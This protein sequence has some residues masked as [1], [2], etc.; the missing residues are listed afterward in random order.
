MIGEEIHKQSFDET[1]KVVARHTGERVEKRQVEEL[2]VR[3]A[4]DFDAFYEER[5]ATP[6]EG[7]A[8]TADIIA[9]TFDGKGVP[10]HPEALRKRTREAAKKAAAKKAGA[11]PL[12]L[13]RPR[14][15]DERRD[16]KRMATVAAVYMTQAFFRTPE[17]V[18]RELNHLQVVEPDGAVRKRP[19]PE[20]KRV[21]ASL[22]KTP[23]EVIAEAFEEAL[24]RDPERKKLWAALVDGNDTQL[25]ALVSLAGEHR[26]TLTI[27]VDFI[28]VAGYVW[29]AAHAF[30]PRGSQEAEVWVRERLLEILRGRSSHVAAGMRRSATLRNFSENERE[31]VDD[32]ADYLLKYRDFL[33]YDEYLAAGLPIATGVIEGACRY[34]VKDRMEL[35]GAVWKLERSEAVLKLRALH[36]SGDFDEYWRFH[37]AQEFKRNHA[38]RYAGEQ[39]PAISTTTTTTRCGN[40]R[41]VV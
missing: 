3:A 9:L 12:S 14:A 31:P 32:C 29:K 17:D 15:A 11:K 20:K 25:N 7:V 1:V 8:N 4:Q 23:E 6:A 26:I 21:W 41:L 33:H 38:S 2:T 18:V 39:P 36:A 35:T 22:K 13:G 27:I 37:V 5:A 19:K 10:M 24:H 40:L 34:L 28:H 30:H 16:R